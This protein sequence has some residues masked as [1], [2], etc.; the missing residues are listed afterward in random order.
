MKQKIKNRTLDDDGVVTFTHAGIFETLFS[1]PTII[2]NA[3]VEQTDEIHTYNKWAKMYDMSELKSSV[4]VNHDKNQLE[5]FMPEKYK[6]L[7]VEA[8]I[9]NQCKTEAQTT[10]CLEELKLYKEKNLY[11]LL[12]YLV[13]LVDTM[14]ENKVFWG[15]GRGSSVSS[16][17]LFL[18]G[19]HRV[20]AIKYKL[21]YRE[22]LK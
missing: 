9:L 3:I 20:D 5:W 7:D 19:I 18:I 21:D 1:D 13:Y 17:V 6:T 2:N 8:F 16:Y 22:F 14:R 11:N 10:R 4:I 15:V 12:K